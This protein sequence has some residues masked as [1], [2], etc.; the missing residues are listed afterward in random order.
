MQSFRDAEF[1]MYPSYKYSSEY[2]HTNS[3]CFRVSMN[4]GASG[5]DGIISSAI[6]FAESTLKRTTLLIGDLATLHDLNA[7]H[8][9]NSPKRKKGALP[10]TSI[11]VNNDGGGIFSFLPIAK[12]GNDVG[13]EEFF[14]TPTSAFSFRKGAEAFG[15]PYEKA[16]SYNEFKYAHMITRAHLQI[17]EASVVSREQ[18]VQV[19]AE[20]TRMVVQD[21]EHYM[22]S[23]D[24]KESEL[25][26]NLK[27]ST[28]IFRKDELRI[29]GDIKAQKS[30]ND[31][32]T[33]VLLHGWMGDKDDW[34]KI[35]LGLL[36]DCF[37]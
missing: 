35:A 11:I 37:D 4:R 23:G 17:M 36:V 28:K 8:N 14:G 25:P 19:H 7:F 20:I 33:L 2:S 5:I 26:S 21:L 12:H 6:G 13:F 18:N 9:L 31:M 22:E 30:N 29:N 24:R 16:S 32:K 10:L 3:D 27:L 34:D 15:L 1:F